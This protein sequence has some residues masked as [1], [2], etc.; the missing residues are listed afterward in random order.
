[1]K[2]ARSDSAP[3]RPL[4]SV[5]G[6]PFS[7]EDKSCRSRVDSGEDVDEEETNELDMGAPF[8]AAWDDGDGDVVVPRVA[9]GMGSR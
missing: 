8:S 2:L 1:M 7:S 9:R 4:K 3:K 6:S 5:N